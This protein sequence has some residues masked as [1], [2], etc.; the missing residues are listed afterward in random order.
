MKLESL[1]ILFNYVLQ[2]T[3]FS[4]FFFVQ[5]VLNL[6]H[7]SFVSFTIKGREL[8]CFLS[9]YFLISSFFLSFF[10]LVNNKVSS[11]HIWSVYRS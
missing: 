4:F 11:L 9:I 1:P 8:P 3:K 10:F 2:E 6:K 5:L 7:D